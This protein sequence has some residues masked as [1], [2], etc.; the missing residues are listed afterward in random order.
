ME[1]TTEEKRAAI[2]Y[3][4]ADNPELE[5]LKARLETFNIFSALSIEQKE[6]QHSNVLAWLLDPEESH[7]LGDIVLKRVL[8]NM[9]LTTEKNDISL[10]A[11]KVELMNWVV[12][13]VKGADVFTAESGTQDGLVNF[14]TASAQDLRS[15]NQTVLDNICAVIE[16]R[17]TIDQDEYTIKDR[18]LKRT[19]LEDLLKL[20]AEYRALVAKDKR[21]E[22]GQGVQ[23]SKVRFKRP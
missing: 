2:D 3:F 21:N 8:S 15:H 19:P 22:K 16:S 14:T 7:G 13:V 18:Q 1:K 6:D 9:L 23:L 17:S 10:S 4:L 12:Q 20:K 5:E 11:A